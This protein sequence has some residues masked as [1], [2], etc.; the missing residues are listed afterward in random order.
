MIRNLKEC[1]VQRVAGGFDGVQ[2][3]IVGLGATATALGTITGI[4]H[5]A[6]QFNGKPNSM[7]CTETCVNITTFVLTCV[8]TAIGVAVTTLS[9]VAGYAPPVPV[10]STI[11]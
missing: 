6:G 9:A 10:N 7:G 4:L 2:T 11:T 3:A 1:E 5:G 8:I